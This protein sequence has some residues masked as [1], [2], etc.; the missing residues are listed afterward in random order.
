MV[1]IIRYRHNGKEDLGFLVDGYIAPFREFG[2][3]Q[4]IEYPLNTE[5]LDLDNIRNLPIDEYLRL[6]IEEVD[7]MQ[8]IKF[9][10][11]I[12]CLGLNYRSHVEEGGREVPNDIVIF[13]KPRTSIIGPYEEVKVPN[14]VK[15]LDY[16]GELAVVIGKKGRFIDEESAYEHVLGYMIL[17]DLSARDYQ[18]RDGQW[19]RGKGFDG[20]APIGPW[21]VTRDEIGEPNDLRIRTWVNDELRQDGNTGDMIFKVPEIIHKISLVMTLEPGDIISTGTPAGVGYF[22]GEDKLL[23][24]GDIVKIEISKIGFIENKIKF[25]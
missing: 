7:I 23:H 9:P 8:P 12:I 4:Y 5:A 24:D 11:K 18:F 19:T 16:E 17:N 21:I 10:G 14:I 15:K 3:P 6:D 22:Q 2:L 1:K 13:L 25:I 20:F